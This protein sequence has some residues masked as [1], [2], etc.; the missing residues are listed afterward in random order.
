M[1]VAVHTVRSGSLPLA[2]KAWDQAAYAWM[3]ALL[4]AVLLVGAFAF[5]FLKRW[6]RRTQNDEVSSSNQLTDFRE[7]YEEGELS[8]EEF[9]R[10]RGV[11]T[12][13]IVREV[14]KAPTPELPPPESP[15]PPN[16]TN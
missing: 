10:I 12:G 2:V 11:L 9:A 7:L 8:S 16:P 5:W 6:Q 3:L 15:Q 13:R 14:N 1:V 4:G